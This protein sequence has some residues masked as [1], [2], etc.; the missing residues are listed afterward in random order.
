M[1]NAIWLGHAAAVAQ[2][3]KAAL[4]GTWANA[5]VATFT[6]NGKNVTSTLTTEANNYSSILN[7]FATALNAS[8]ISEFEEITWAN[9]SDTHIQGTAD[10]AGQPFTATNSEVT[11]GT[12]NL[13]D[14]AVTTEGGG[15]YSA[16]TADNWSTGATPANN[17]AVIFE[18]SDVDCLYDLGVLS[19]IEPVSISIKQSYTGKIGLPRINVDG[20]TADADKYVEY[21]TRYLTMSPTTVNIGEGEGT[22]SGR[23]MLDV[24]TS[25]APVTTVYNRGSREET[26]IPCTL[27][28]GGNAA[29]S[30]IV[31]KGDV[32]LAFFAGETADVTAGCKI[33]YV[34]NKLS[35]SSV[36]CGDGLTFGNIDQSG[37][38]LEF[39]DNVTTFTQHDGEATIRGA[40]TITTLT[41][42]G[43]FYS[44][45]TGTITTLNV[46]GRGNFDHSRSMDAKTITNVNLYSGAA[47]R[48]PNGVLTETNNID[49]EQ[50]SLFDRNG[51]SD[52]II[53]KPVNKT[54]AFSA[55]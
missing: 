47:Y 21:R 48:D 22:G 39:E 1:A 40:A 41:M 17:D 19:A 43:T 32:G 15:P 37:G 13:A 7:T 27:L 3:Q 9:S 14:F 12:G 54:V 16:N 23:I 53:Q 34:D 5:D 2:V 20:G 6:I 31:L 30:L 35:D 50:C 4:Q 52:V 36:V 25:S 42:A 29:A 26:G 46:T 24:G 44:Y 51:A 45:G 10:T 38:T 11:A 18:N 28:K 55:I 49:L 8:T 33:S